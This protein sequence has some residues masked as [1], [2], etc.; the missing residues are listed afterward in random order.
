MKNPNK[1]IHCKMFYWT[2]DWLLNPPKLVIFNYIF[3][4][5]TI[6]DQHL[7]QIYQSFKPEEIQHN[8]TKWK[9]FEISKWISDKN[10]QKD[11]KID[12]SRSD[13]LENI[14]TSLPYPR[15]LLTNS[16]WKILG[17]NQKRNPKKLSTLLDNK[18]H[19]LVA[20]SMTS[21]KLGNVN[22]SQLETAKK[23]KWNFW[24]ES[25]CINF[26]VKKT[27]V[28]KATFGTADISVSSLF[29]MKICFES[30]GLL[31]LFSIVFRAFEKYLR[32]NLFWNLLDPLS[33]CN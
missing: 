12:L 8:S 3:I 33:A 14:N 13:C 1:P 18:L 20:T 24:N 26:L 15:T 2:V 27:G 30:F 17:L 25:H 16:Y 6:T 28:V 19:S 23:G 7:D 21:S 10:H 9:L 11:S 29:F 31:R 22:S 4:N 5:Q 32:N